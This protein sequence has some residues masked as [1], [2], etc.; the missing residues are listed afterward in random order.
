MTRDRLLGQARAGAKRRTCGVCDHPVYNSR[1]ICRHCEADLLIRL[2]NQAGFLE[3]LQ[4]ERRK[5]DRKQAANSRTKKSKAASQPLP[6][7]LDI[8]PLIDRQRST[9]VRWARDLRSTPSVLALIEHYSGWQG[10]VCLSCTHR[11]CE[12][13][14]SAQWP[15]NTIAAMSL[16]IYAHVHRAVKSEDA[17][18]LAVDIANLTQD[19]LRVIDN[20]QATHNYGPCPNRWPTPDGEEDWCPGE[21]RVRMPSDQT[22]PIEAK[23]TACGATWPYET[24]DVLEAQISAR[25]EQEQAAQSKSL[26]MS[27]KYRKEPA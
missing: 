2:T 22:S 13:W 23:C 11:S 3:D 19:I 20:P 27:A 17:V 1:E 24:L 18:L 5:Q 16:W 14:R 9:I 21:V 12:G 10:P 4:V 6:V 26:E 8:R 7:D 15:A 25:Q